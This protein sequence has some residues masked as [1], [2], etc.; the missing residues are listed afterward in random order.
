LTSALALRSRHAR[1]ATTLSPTAT[2]KP[3]SRRMRGSVLLLVAR[4]FRTSL[5]PVPEPVEPVGKSALAESQAAPRPRRA[6]TGRRRQPVRPHQ[7]RRSAP[8]RRRCR[9][10]PRRHGRP[11]ED[12]QARRDRPAGY[13]QAKPLISRMRA[14][15]A[16]S[17]EA[18]ARDDDQSSAGTIGSHLAPASVETA[19]AP[20]L[21]PSMQLSGPHG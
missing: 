2:E 8:T 19:V 15:P 1:S 3:P 6:R 14:S 9:A 16:V 21:S 18:L 12:H 17:A 5:T 11:G 4:P 7:A 10:A 20:P 13:S